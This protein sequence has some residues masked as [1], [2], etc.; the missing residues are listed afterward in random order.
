M[1]LYPGK[2]LKA[3]VDS[4]VLMSRTGQLEPSGRMTAE[5]H[6]FSLNYN[7]RFDTYI[8]DWYFHRSPC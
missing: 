2:T 3:T 4:V 8:L 6:P 7:S 5:L 1:Q